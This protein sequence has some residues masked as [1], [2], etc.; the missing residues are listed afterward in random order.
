MKS[1]MGQRIISVFLCMVT[2]SVIC[3]W[4]IYKIGQSETT[5]GSAYNGYTLTL[6]SQRGTIF[7]CNLASLT[8]SDTKILAA[9]TPT[10]R[11]I[12]A[13]S[14]VLEGEELKAV[15]NTLREGKPAVVE[16]D[17]EIESDGIICVKVYENVSRDTVC[18]HLIGYLGA[19]GHGVSGIQKAYD[20]LLFSG[21]TVKVI[22]PSDADGDFLVGAEPEV[23]NNESVANSGIALTI[24]RDIQRVSEQAMGEVECGAAVVMEV[25]SGKI[26]A[27]VSRPSFDLS[28]ISDY[29]ERENSPLV[30]RALSAYNVGSVFKPCVAAALIENGGSEGYTCTCTGS[31]VIAGHTFGC[32]NLSGHGNMNLS[33]AIELSCNSFF[34]EF[35]QRLGADKIYNQAKI[36]SFGTATDI[37]GILTDSGSIGSYTRLSSSETALANLSIG[38][39]ELLLSPISILPLYEAIA[40]GG[41]YYTP[42]VIEGTVTGGVI[43][44]RGLSAPTRAMSEETAEKLKEYLCRVVVS[45]TGTAAAPESTTAAGKTATAETG[46]RID[47]ELI[48]NSWFCGFFPSENPKYA[49]SVLIENEKKNNI[50]GA[51]IFKKIAD[52]ITRLQ[53]SR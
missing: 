38:Q 9:V 53:K 34:Y 10:P 39:G 14:G 29:L 26:R 2:V 30:N 11:A 19:D 47:G 18:E 35:S 45:G 3:F 28:R 5:A 41:I 23:I 40:N 16:L 48:Q 15:L 51:P 49:V 46:W 43:E 8:N 50:T 13:I 44:R 7:D 1:K 24:D 27:M 21:D 37:G 32:H 33:S 22:Y 6:S 4:R 36:F 20:E 25:G 31:V 17:S 12:T 52:G 42:T